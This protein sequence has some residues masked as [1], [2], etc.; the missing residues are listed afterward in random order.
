MKLSH[1]IV[2]AVALAAACHATALAQQSSAGQAQDG[3]AAEAGASENQGDIVVTA[4]RRNQS[5]LKTPLA[6][7]VVSSE[8]LRGNG[9][10]NPQNLPDLLPSVQNGVAGFA[11]RGIS[12]GD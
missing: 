1:S 8:S 2:S 10:T 11:I 7:S 3:P 5:L 12:S 6:I 9:I 4:Q